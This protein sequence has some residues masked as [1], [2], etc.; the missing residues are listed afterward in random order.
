MLVMSIGKAERRSAFL[1]PGGGC[2]HGTCQDQ[3]RNSSST[4]LTALHSTP[5]AG[6]RRKEAYSKATDKRLDTVIRAATCVGKNQ[7]LQ[8]PS[9]DTSCLYSKFQE[10]KQHGVEEESSV[11]GVFLCPPIQ[12]LVTAVH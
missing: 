12:T 3:E 7:Q 10:F 4:F 1:A 8:T 11:E 9:L 5:S 2:D 6:T